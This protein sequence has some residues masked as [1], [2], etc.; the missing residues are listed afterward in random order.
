MRA[1]NPRDVNASTVQPRLLPSDSAAP[2]TRS[3]TIVLQ[4]VT[5]LALWCLDYPLMRSVDGSTY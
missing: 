3:V 5:Q 2:P 1:M 4:A